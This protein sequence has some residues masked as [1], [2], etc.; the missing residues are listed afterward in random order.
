M[1]KRKN[2]MTAL[3][4]ALI[5]MLT[6]TPA[7]AFAGVNNAEDIPSSYGYDESFRLNC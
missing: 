6:M 3:L 1:S 2:K 5:M 7:M 4:V